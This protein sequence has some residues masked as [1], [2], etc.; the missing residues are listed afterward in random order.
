M[1]VR[2][3][4]ELESSFNIGFH[5]TDVRSWE[6]IIPQLFSRLDH[7]NHF[8]QQQLC[9]LLCRIAINSPQLVVY[10]TLVALNSHG[11]SEQSKQLLLRIADSLD[12]SNG[13]LIAEIRR[14][15]EE[16]KHITVLW[17]E[18]WFNKLNGLQLDINKRFHKVEKE[19]ERINDNLNLSSD[20]RTKFMKESYDTIMKPIISSIERLC[21]NTIAIAS[22]PHEKWF[23]SKFGNRIN[24]SLKL[25]RTP[26]S[27]ETYKEGWDLLRNVSRVSHSF[28]HHHRIFKTEYHFFYLFSGSERII[29]SSSNE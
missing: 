1:L 3:G 15:I 27:I 24:E 12:H 16:L 25:L 6:S 4:S 22:T 14:V 8:V 17:E 13:A 20:Q 7:P 2:Y 26:S 9:Q 19:F 28:Y 10:N 29:Q 5:N 11:T 23:L 18:M 21:N